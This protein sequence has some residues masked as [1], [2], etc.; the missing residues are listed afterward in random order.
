MRKDGFEIG[1]HG[2]KHDGKL[3]FSRKTFSK[4]VKEINEYSKIYNAKG[5]R[6]PLTHRN[7]EWVQELECEYDMPFF[8]TDRYETMPGGTMS[9]WPFFMGHFVELPYTLVQDH[10]LFVILREKTPRI[11]VE[12]ADFIEKYR[13]M[14]LVNVHPDYLR[15]AKYLALYEAFLQAMKERGGYW[16]ALPRD[17]ARWW[18]RRAAA[19]IEEKDGKWIAR[20]LPEATVGRIQRVEGS[21]VLSQR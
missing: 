13:G 15:G 1:I 21:L 2:L 6:S 14:V 20:D 5:F 8:D 11:W 10:T 16:H 9:I 4:R 19:A 3:F 7:P 18:R 12:K 17:V